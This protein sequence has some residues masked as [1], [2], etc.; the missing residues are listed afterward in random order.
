MVEHYG[1]QRN[2]T[3]YEHVWN[4]SHRP[5][6][7]TMSTNVYSGRYIKWCSMEWRVCKKPTQKIAFLRAT[8][9]L[10][11]RALFSG[12]VVGQL[13]DVWNVLKITIWS[14]LTI[15]SNSS[16]CVLTVEY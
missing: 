1:K 16:C 6:T 15:S 4:K 7:E 8:A 13:Y 10:A 2:N 5:D 9:S 12:V 3:L 11:I 14:W